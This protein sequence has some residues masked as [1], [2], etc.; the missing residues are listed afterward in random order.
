M[1]ASEPNQT[2]STSKIK[3]IYHAILMRIAKTILSYKI[4]IRIY[5]HLGMSI[6]KDTY[7]G[8]GLELI[9]QTLS[10]LVV[11]GDR[12]TISPQVTLV[13]SAGP[14][15]SRLRKVYPRKFGKIVIEDDAWVG[16]GAIILPGVTIGKMS[17]VGAGAV[18]I[19]DVP[20][21]TVVAGVPA[22]AIKKLEIKNENSI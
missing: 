6:G 2:P 15:N 7:V 5:R 4:R 11:L 20:P 12:V 13:V 8:P 17:V 18:V 19:E 21:Y 9:D 16:T 14:N 22:R 1:N 10:N 3:Q